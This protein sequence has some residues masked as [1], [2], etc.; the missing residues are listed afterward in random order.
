M[1]YTYAHVYAYIYVCIH[2]YIH[3]GLRSQLNRLLRKGEAAIHIYSDG[4]YTKGTRAHTPSQGMTAASSETHTRRCRNQAS[5]LALSGAPVAA[6]QAS[7]L[8]H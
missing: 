3:I 1:M 2:I 4:V 8:A 7:S 5:S 6:G